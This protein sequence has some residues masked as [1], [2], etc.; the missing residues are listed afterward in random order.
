MLPACDAVNVHVPVPLVIVT[1]LP[2]IV[3]APLAAM[4]TARPEVEDAL[5]ANVEA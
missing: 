1:V 4:V 2:D 5:T 3:H